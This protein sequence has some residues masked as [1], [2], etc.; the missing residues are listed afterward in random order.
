MHQNIV[1]LHAANGMLNKDADLTQGFIGGLLLITQLRVGVLL[2]PLASSTRDRASDR[3]GPGCRTESARAYGGF[4]WLST[5]PSRTVSPGHQRLDRPYNNRGGTGACLL[6]SGV[7][8]CSPL[9]VYAC[10]FRTRPLLHRFSAGL[11]G[12]CH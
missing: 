12:T 4:R 9:Q 3:A 1:A 8:L 11:P 7:C 10:V 6:S 2:T 5:V